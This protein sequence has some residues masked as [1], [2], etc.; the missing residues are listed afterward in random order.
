M[1]GQLLQLKK[2]KKTKVASGSWFVSDLLGYVFRMVVGWRSFLVLVW[3]A[4]K[5]NYGSSGVFQVVLTQ[6][7]FKFGFLFF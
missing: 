4:R 5:S 2:K 1:L 7:S 3:P 6:M